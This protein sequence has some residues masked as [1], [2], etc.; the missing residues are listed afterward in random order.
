MAVIGIDRYREWPRLHNAVSDARGACEAFSKLGFR[1]VG[2]P[3]L[4]EAA[5]YAALH[6]LVTD[7]LCRLGKEDSL[8]LFFAGHGHTLTSE[9]ADGETSKRGYI[10]PVDAEHQSRDTWLRLD[11]WLSEVAHLPPK[12]ILV[13][14]DACYSGI[15]LDPRVVTRYRD[16]G[17]PLD[18]QLESLRARK[19]R[20][21][22]TSALDDQRAMDS[23]P[24][25]G[26]S[27]FTGCLIEALT[28]GLA[29]EQRRPLAT[30]SEIGGYVRRRVSEYPRSQQTPDFGTLE[31][32]NRGELIIRLPGFEEPGPKR[33]PKGPKKH[34]R[35]RRVGKQKRTRPRRRRPDVIARPTLPIDDVPDLGVDLD[36]A[37]DPDPVQDTDR[38]ALDPAFVAA[39]DRHAAERSR[40][41]RVLS[42]IAGE[43]T[44]TLAGWAEW[45]ARHGYLTLATHGAGPG[46]TIADL[47]AQIPWLRCVAAARAS[48]AT[49]AGLD[50]DAVDASLDARSGRE[51]AAWIHD[52]AALDRHAQ[53]SGWLLSTLR[54]PRAS[55]PDL[56]TA[57]VQ[58]GELLAILCKLAAPIA[59]LVHH[60]EPTASWLERA[61][62]TAAALVTHLPEHAVAVGAPADLVTGVLGSDRQSAALSMARQGVV[63]IAA[64]AQGS[65]VRTR[66]RAARVLH[67]ALARDARTAGRF[68]L[69]VEVPIRVGGPSIEVDLVARS[70]RLAVEIDS[71][72]HFRDPQGYRAA[73]VTDV[74]LQRAGYFVL[75]FLAEDVGER[76]PR[77]VDEI[78]VALRGRRGSRAPDGESL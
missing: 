7:D 13:I 14:L 21:I 9:Y 46:E 65:A 70:A 33:K 77:I 58:G 42:V 22:I 31:L 54:E 8:V 4:D 32:D 20:R 62:V 34:S 29:T 28:G 66:S 55:V 15:A 19:S 64:R 17:A 73:R 71:W 2:E 68:A 74:R 3:L 75:R 24:R 41:A 39:L 61:I 11:S 1:Q 18:A 38:A 56:T 49:A 25:P 60:P 53:V 37:P 26:H 44:V 72:Y 6:R 23:G 51:R 69:D 35:A 57:P 40:G 76:L 27:L 78:A 52:V 43:T 48:L 10:L 30:G 67:E 63:S 12:H 45:A 16:G 36:S 47:L 59:V 5:T 50:V